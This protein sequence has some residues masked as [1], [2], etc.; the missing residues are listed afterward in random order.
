MI[1][2]T[3]WMW[4]R[5][6]L[7]PTHRLSLMWLLPQHHHHHLNLQLKCYFCGGGSYYV[8]RHC[9]AR[10]TICGNCGI[11]GHNTKCCLSK[12]KSTSITAS[13]YPSLCAT[14]ITVSFLSNLQIAGTSVLI[15]GYFLIALIDSGNF[16][17]FIC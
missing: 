2:P 9:P 11:R 14:G 7:I 12:K 3:L 15:N 10:E 1:R 13:L 4:P 17:S 16:D 6:M 5:E 8:R